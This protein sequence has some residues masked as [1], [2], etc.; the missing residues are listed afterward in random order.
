ML[1]IYLV[2]PNY[3]ICS[4]ANIPPQQHDWWAEVALDQ[5]V[6]GID[7]R[8]ET[9]KVSQELRKLVEDFTKGCLMDEK[10]A[11]ENKGRVDKDR[12]RA[13]GV[14]RDKMEECCFDPYMPQEGY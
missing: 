10:Q 14:I 3:R 7:A 11:K 1:L 2:D 8:P 4:T 6:F 12:A 5:T 13:S 9:R